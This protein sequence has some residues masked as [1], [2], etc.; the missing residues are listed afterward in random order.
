MLVWILGCLYWCLFVFVWDCVLMICLVV[1][2][3]FA[4]WLILLVVGAYILVTNGCCVACY[5]W[6]FQVW[7]VGIPVLICFCCL[8]GFCLTCWFIFTV[9]RFWLD[10]NDCVCCVSVLG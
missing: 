7:C 2:C 4:V 5:Y 6:L 1:G 3:W 8:I 10:F 9:D